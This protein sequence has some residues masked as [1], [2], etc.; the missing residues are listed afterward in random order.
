MNLHGTVTLLCAVKCR[1]KILMTVKIHVNARH[2][3]HTFG[4][5]RLAAHKSKMQFSFLPKYSI[6]PKYTADYFNKKNNN[7]KN[8]E[9]VKYK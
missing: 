9:A 4:C 5:T 2:T 7:I 8:L 1:G 3:V 6:I